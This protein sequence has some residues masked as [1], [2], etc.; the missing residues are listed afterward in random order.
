MAKRLVK[1][2]AA[3]VGIVVVVVVVAVFVGCLV[4]KLNNA[5]QKVKVLW[6]SRIFSGHNPPRRTGQH[7]QRIK[8]N[9]QR[10]TNNKRQR[11]HG[12]VVAS[13]LRMRNQKRDSNGNHRPCTMWSTNETIKINRR[14][15]RRRRCRRRLQGR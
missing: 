4:V 9:V 14:R 12:L 8:N 7:R 6:V 11:Q 2:L 5:T 13:W 10:T 3:A 1:F 15:R